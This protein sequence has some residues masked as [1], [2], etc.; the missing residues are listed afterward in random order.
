MQSIA[1]FITWYLSRRARIGRGM[2]NLVLLIVLAPVF[3]LQYQHMQNIATETQHY[4]QHIQHSG[5]DLLTQTDTLLKEL[6]QVQKIFGMSNDSVLL[7]TCLLI[8][9]IPLFLMRL[10]DAG[11]WNEKGQITLVLFMYA[12]PIIHVLEKHDAFIL[13]TEL[14]LLLGMI[15]FILMGWLC[16]KNSAR[17]TISDIH[18]P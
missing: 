7:E 17:R 14:T 16:T 5:L 2:F 15:S 1:Q 13:P 3:Y 11:I 12:S 8:L 9:L 6:D 4:V 18:A 10:R